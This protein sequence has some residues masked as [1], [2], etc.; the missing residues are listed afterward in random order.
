MSMPLYTL[1]CVAMLSCSRLLGVDSG[2]VIAI[3]DIRAVLAP[4]EAAHVGRQ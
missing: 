3:Q 1:R 2:D 4:R